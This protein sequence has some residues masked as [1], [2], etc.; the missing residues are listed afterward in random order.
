MSTDAD[1]KSSS[2]PKQSQ[3]SVGVRPLRIWI[4]MILL[5]VMI[6]LRFSLHVFGENPVLIMPAVFGPLVCCL[7]LV[8]WWLAASRATIKEKMVGLVGIVVAA[9]A[10]AVLAHPSMRGPTMIFVTVPMGFG[11]FGLGAILCSRC[12]IMKRAMSAAVFAIVGFGFSILLRSEGMWGNNEFALRWRWIPTAEEQF[13]AGQGKAPKK[14]LDELSLV[15]IDQKLTVPDWS[16]FRG[17]RRDGVQS[18]TKI[19][20]SWGD[21][22]PKP[23]WKVNVGPGWASFAVAGG[24]IFTQEQRGEVEA[25]V[26]YD[27]N[28]GGEVWKH[29]IKTRFDDPLGGP[30]PR[31]TPTI[32]DGKLFAL[33]ANGNLVCLEPKTGKMVWNKDLQEVASRKPPTWGFSGSPLVVGK[34]VIVH[35]GGDDELGTIAFDVATGDLKWSVAAGDHSYCSPTLVKLAN[36]V[37]VAML[38]NMELALIDPQSGKVVFNYECESPGY[39]ALQPQVVDGRSVLMVT[40]MGVGTHRIDFK[41]EGGKWSAEEA[42]VSKRL[43]P[44]FN[45]FVVI[46]NYAYGFDGRF[47]TCIDVKDGSRKWRAGRYGKGQVLGL[48]SGQLLVVTESGEVVLLSADPQSH[49]ELVRFKAL[50]GKTWNHPVIVG[51]RL[52]LRNSKEAACFQ[53][54][55]EKK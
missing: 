36:Q 32:A 27:A 42:W 13:L 2:L 10:T 28:S 6:C 44:D 3:E 5:V 8:I 46:D 29:E 39:R 16:G 23:L 15:S 45:D 48:D 18:G 19:S 31:A 30:G 40:G 1:A 34:H 41:F 26:C 25:V 51:D 50:E 17:P 11:M 12:G 37:V 35:A 33:G 38:T 53:L 7:L 22:T 14:T 52:Y 20:A 54:P 4:P 49:R 43:K 47:F 24:L 55:V 21:D 9:A